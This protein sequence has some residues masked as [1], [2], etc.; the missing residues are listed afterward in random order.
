M[1][2]TRAQTDFWSLCHMTDLM[3][4]AESSKIPACC[5]RRSCKQGQS[6]TQWRSSPIGV[7]KRA[8][9]QMSWHLR[10]LNPALL[11]RQGMSTH[12]KMENGS[13]LCHRQHR[14][15][16]ILNSFDPMLAVAKR[17]RYSIQVFIWPVQ[18]EA[19]SYVCCSSLGNDTEHHARHVL[20]LDSA[21]HPL[22]TEPTQHHVH[23]LMLTETSTSPEMQALNIPGYISFTSSRNVKHALAWRASRGVACHIKDAIARRFGLWRVS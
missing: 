9:A 14:M 4:S 10:H 1:A 6:D 23:N 15:K 21:L 16:P 18:N 22:D 19:M 5:C 3:A 13:E 2:N 12:S 11:N 8:P 17:W 7:T 20:E